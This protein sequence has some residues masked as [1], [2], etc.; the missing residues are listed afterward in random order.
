M[1]TTLR[2]AAKCLP[3]WNES[4]RRLGKNSLGKCRNFTTTSPIQRTAN[5]F[6]YNFSSLSSKPPLKSRPAFP[7]PKSKDSRYFKNSQPS[8]SKTNATASTTTTTTSLPPKQIAW[9]KLNFPKSLSKPSFFDELH[10]KKL[11]SK[12]NYDAS[13]RPMSAKNVGG[14]SKTTSRDDSKYR[15]AQNQRIN[16][17]RRLRKPD[18]MVETR[19]WNR[20]S[21]KISSIRPGQG[22]V[23]TAPKERG[24]KVNLA[25]HNDQ[26]PYTLDNSRNLQH[27]DP[28]KTSRSTKRNWPVKR[29]PKLRIAWLGRSNSQRVD[30]S[31]SVVQWVYVSDGFS[32]GSRSKIGQAQSDFNRISSYTVK[33]NELHF[34][35]IFRRGRS[36]LVSLTFVRY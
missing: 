16:D 6:K 14:K 10:V 7:K 25:P 35:R 11:W 29:S 8:I 4:L 33:T 31:S 21:P 3:S 19:L 13:Q 18:T 5:M 26:L 27:Q 9:P 20:R 32:F 30:S 24:L 15:F 22:L 17:S 12:A 2:F 23:E 34:F 36:T 1:Q 28:L